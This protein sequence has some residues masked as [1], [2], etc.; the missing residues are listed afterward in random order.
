MLISNCLRQEEHEA[1]ERLIAYIADYVEVHRKDYELLELESNTIY[2]VL[3][4]AYEQGNR[5][6]W[7]VLSAP[8]PRF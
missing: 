1:Y 7:S 8:L 4:K 2:L 6:N 5:P 3:S